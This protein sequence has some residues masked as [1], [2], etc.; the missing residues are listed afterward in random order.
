MASR[1]ERL[2]ELRVQ[3][4]EAENT[5]SA[6]EQAQSNQIYLAQMDREE[7]QLQLTLAEEEYRA[8]EEVISDASVATLDAVKDQMELAVTQTEGVGAGA[9]EV[10]EANAAALGDAESAEAAAQEEAERLAQAN[11]EQPAGM[12]AAEA[13]AAEDQ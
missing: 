13:P 11:A 9:K 6:R 3:V 12:P 4:T 10:D 1:S 8:S 5:R 2:D 7:A